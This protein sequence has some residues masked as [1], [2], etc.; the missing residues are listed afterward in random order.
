MRWRGL[1]VM[2]LLARKSWSQVFSVTLCV[3]NFPAELVAEAVPVKVNRKIFCAFDLM[4]A[5]QSPA[6]SSQRTLC[7]VFM[8]FR[9]KQGEAASM[10]CFPQSKGRRKKAEGRR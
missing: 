4:A 2:L 7:T 8:E 9:V 3:T 6:T 1:L 5:R 10:G